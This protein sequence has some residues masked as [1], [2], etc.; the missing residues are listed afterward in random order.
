MK[1]LEKTS[2]RLAK[3]SVHASIAFVCCVEIL[4][5]FYSRSMQLTAFQHK[6]RI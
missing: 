1:M 5:T 6:K 4:I 2:H 3:R